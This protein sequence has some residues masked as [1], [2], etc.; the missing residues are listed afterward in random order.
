V[1][2][3]AAERIPTKLTT[4]VITTMAATSPFNPGLKDERM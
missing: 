3:A 1:R 2:I 4:S